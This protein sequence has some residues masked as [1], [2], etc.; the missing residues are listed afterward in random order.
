MEIDKR[1]I[2]VYKIGEE[3]GLTA[4]VSNAGACLL[5]LLVLDDQGRMADVVLGSGDPCAAL[6]PGPMFGVTLGRC[7]G[8]TR[9]ARYTYRGQ[10][11]KLSANK[12][13]HHGHGGFR[14]FDKR[15][16]ALEHIEKDRVTFLYDSPDG[17]EGYPGK[18]QLHVSYRIEGMKLSIHYYAVSDADTP[19]N[20]TN[21]IYWNLNGYDA[22]DI[23]GH[24]LCL[25]ARWLAALDEELIPTGE[26]VPVAGTVTE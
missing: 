2:C 15:V 1:D 25:N 17:E 3:G 24:E 12:G 23:S 10:T 14:G 18:V 26:L 16:F 9:A 6:R 8:K 20:I 21:H 13:C 22:A 19:L 7:A 4:E 11:V 5:S